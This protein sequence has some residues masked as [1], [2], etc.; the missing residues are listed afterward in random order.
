MKYRNAPAGRVKQLYVIEFTG[1]QVV[2]WIAT[3]IFMVAGCFLLGTCLSASN[4]PSTTDVNDD[5]LPEKSAPEEGAPVDDRR[6]AFL[7]PP[8]AR[9]H[10]EPVS[11]LALSPDGGF[12]ATTSWDATIKVWAV[13]TGE[14]VNKCFLDGII[15][16]ALALS[17]GGRY[18]ACWEPFEMMKAL[19]IDPGIDL[20]QVW[21]L[22]QQEMILELELAV[23]ACAFSP[24]GEY[25]VLLDADTL[26]LY[27]TRTWR[28]VELFPVR[29][30]ETAPF[31]HPSVGFGE[32][33]E[34]I[35]ILDLERCVTINIVD[36]TRAVVQ[37]EETAGKVTEAALLPLKPFFAAFIN[38]RGCF[39]RSFDSGQALESMAAEEIPQG[40]MAFTPDGRCLAVGNPEGWIDLLSV[41]D[42]KRIHRFNRYADG[43]VALPDSKHL[44]AFDTYHVI[45]FSIEGA[46]LIRYFSDEINPQHYRI[47]NMEKENYNEQSG[48][49]KTLKPEMQANGN[50]TANYFYSLKQP[51]HASYLQCLSELYYRKGDPA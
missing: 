44:I 24:D 5:S 28:L 2:F 48:Q 26:H 43:L 16:H 34:E 35:T 4:K 38:E 33:E 22:E 9:A 19:G 6:A 41:P 8:Y 15:W 13:G 46:P 14:R 32:I 47:R 21:D 45:L 18:V 17:P 10:E 50:C 40:P 20:V 7:H 31:S 51:S 23:S 36:G 12:L 42:C 49:G 11:A 37:A 39:V 27:S 1:A 25:M 30:E 3:L 29:S